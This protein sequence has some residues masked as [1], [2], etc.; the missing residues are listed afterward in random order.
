MGHTKEFDISAI[1]NACIDIIDNV[2]DEFL[3]DFSLRKSCCTRVFEQDRNALYKALKSPQQIP[4][5]VGNNTIAVVQA[6]GGN[7]AFLPIHPV[8]SEVFCLNTEDG[9]RTFASYTPE[10]LPSSLHSFTAEEL[11]KSSCIFLDGYTL[12][13]PGSAAIF[14]ETARIACENNIDVCFN[15]CDLSVIEAH[16]AEIETLLKNTTMLICNYAEAQAIFGP[17]TLEDMGTKLAAQFKAGAITSGE[18]GAVVF[19]NG[20]TAFIPPADISNLP[21]IDSNGAGDHF[22]GAFLYGMT[23]GFTLEQA[24]KLGQLCALDCLSHAGARPLGSLQHLVSAL[25]KI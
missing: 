17:S 13:M 12:A 6:L 18:D 20:K 14:E 4:G 16:T 9:D 10:I 22:A 19:A 7:A 2:S 21:T 15:P 3:N 1:G 5:G 11:S 25:T 23:H 8:T 24:G